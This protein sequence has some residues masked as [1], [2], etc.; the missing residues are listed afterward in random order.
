MTAITLT[1]NAVKELKRVQQEQSIPG[2]DVVRVK[3]QGGGCAGFSYS[4][5]FESGEEVG[6]ADNIYEFDGIRVAVDKKSM[7]YL[8]GTTIDWLEDLNHRGFNFENPNAVRS[9]G[10]NKSFGV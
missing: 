1:E 5:S 2:T 10:C 4:M 8:E 3:I 6:E 9:C 7:L